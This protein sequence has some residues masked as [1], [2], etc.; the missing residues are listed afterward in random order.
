MSEYFNYQHA[1]SIVLM[2]TAIPMWS[3]V[4]GGAC[5]VMQRL[6]EVV[7]VHAHALCPKGV[8]FDAEI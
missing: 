4:F 2:T 5:R 6:C 8:K 3:V 7:H 1:H